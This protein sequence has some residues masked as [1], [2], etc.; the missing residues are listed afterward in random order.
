M[1][2]LPSWV[3]GR[4]GSPAA[5][6]SV[7]RLLRTGGLHTVC[8]S[9]RCPNLGECFSLGTATFLILG[10]RCTRDCAF[11]AVP[12][13]R[14]AAPDPGEPYRVAAAAQ[15]L[16]LDHVVVTSVTRDDLPDGGS[17]HF[18]RTVVALRRRLPGATVE[19]LTPDFG[20]DTAAVERVAAS[21]PH[22]FNHNLETVPRL[23]ERVRPGADYGRSLAVLAAARRAGPGLRTKSGL[24]V[25]LGET[26]DEVAAVFRDLREAGCDMVTVGQYLQ[27]AR[28]RLPVAAYLE[29]EAFAEYE[30]MAREAGLAEVHAGPLVRSSY[31]AGAFAGAGRG[32]GG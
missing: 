21:G 20:G 11:C 15:R 25:G 14:P 32:A 17:G 19:V 22:V 31:R 18:A 8:E 29:P 7:K 13:G 2:R 30:A 5:V 1:P 10:D 12:H 27:P 26:R 24:M 28:D 9:A 16:G 23:Y 3:R 4:G 6:R